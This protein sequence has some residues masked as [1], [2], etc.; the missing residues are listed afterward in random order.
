LAWE[1]ARKPTFLPRKNS[2]DG[3]FPGAFAQ[4]RLAVYDAFSPE[5]RDLFLTCKRTLSPKHLNALTEEAVEWLS[6]RANGDPNA[7]SDDLLRDKVDELVFHEVFGVDRRERYQ[8]L[9]DHLY[10][11]PDDK[12]PESDSEATSDRLAVW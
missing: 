9:F 3:P 1:L 2:L 8:Q 6:E 10:K 11:I 4:S 12:S 7:F 5:D